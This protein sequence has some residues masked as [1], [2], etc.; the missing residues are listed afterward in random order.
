MLLEDYN[1]VDVYVEDTGVG[2]KKIFVELL[3]KAFKNKYE[4]QHIF[5]LGSR[6]VVIEECRANQLSD[7][8]KKVF[9]VDGDL[10]ILRGEATEKLKGLFVLPR[11]SIENFLLDEK[12][13]T[14]VLYEEDPEI[15]K[16]ELTKKLDFKRWVSLNEELLVNL[17]TTY[18]VV[19]KLTPETLT[20]GY[21][22]NRLTKD[23]NG[24]VCPVK[25]QKRIDQLYT[26]TT[27]QI[28]KNIYTSEWEKISSR[29]S[30]EDNKL[31]KYVS[32]K[33]YLI[34]L[35]KSRCKSFMKLSASNTNLFIRLA[36]KSDV[37]DLDTVI[38]YVIE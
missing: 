17:F 37:K 36:I 38:N 1:D 7:G 6:D 35:I 10:Y 34:P 12:A 16:E 19:H 28:E 4:I 26:N 23:G 31:L 29:I 3:N 5:P 2:F 27:G 18:A 32:G 20:V 11:Y 8:R 22:V 24:V 33:D 25:T 13:I 15:T 21:K 14:E 9:I 30:S